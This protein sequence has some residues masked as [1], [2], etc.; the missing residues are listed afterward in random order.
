MRKIFLSGANSDLALT[1]ITNLTS[2]I[3]YEQ[4]VIDD[5]LVF[6]GKGRGGNSVAENVK[7]CFLSLLKK[8]LPKHSF[9]QFER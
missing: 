6:L 9:R 1:Y 3:K 8:H 7:K 5:E 4:E 2:K